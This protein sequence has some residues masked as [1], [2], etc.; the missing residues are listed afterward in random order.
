MN[1]TEISHK[2]M[3]SVLTKPGYEIKTQLTAKDCHHIHMAMGIAGE[4]GE[5]LDAV[6]KNTMYRKPLD[7][8]NI[9]EELGDIEFY[10]EGLRASLGISRQEVLEANI[11]KLNKRYTA[12]YSDVAAIIRA[13]K[14]VA[15]T[16]DDCD[17]K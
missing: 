13:D 15:K 9:I 3:V 12:G 6:K 17:G 7:L 14:I 4:A 11:V 2:N 10:M 5:L 8:T 1:T 16:G